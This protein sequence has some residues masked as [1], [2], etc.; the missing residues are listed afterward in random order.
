MGSWSR[1][2]II[3]CVIYIILF[4]IALVWETGR[5]SRQKMRMRMT[6]RI[7]VVIAE[8]R[9]GKGYSEDPF[10]RYGYVFTVLDEYEGVTFDG[11]WSFRVKTKHTSLP[12]NTIKA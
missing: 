2:D 4:I 11:R 3:N 10:H 9:E 7:N 1:A 5:A 8:I 6:K 12:N